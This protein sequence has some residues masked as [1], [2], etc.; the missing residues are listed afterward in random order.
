MIISKDDYT[1]LKADQV[2]GRYVVNEQLIAFLNTMTPTFKVETVGRSVEGRPVQGVT[3][4]KGKKRILMWSQMHGN[5][6]TTTKAVLDL[7]KLL[8]SN[9]NVAGQIL[10]HCTLHIIPILN[11]DGA[12]A[13]TRLNANQVDLNRD[14]QNR[15]QPE[16]V[17]LRDSYDNFKPDFCFNLHDQRTIYN[18]GTSSK[19]ATVSFLAPAHDVERSISNKRATAMKLIVAM[20]EMLQEIIPGQ[21]GRYDDAFNANCIGDTFQMLNTPTLLF[22]AGHTPG[23]YDREQTREYIFYAMVKALHVI[24]NDTIDR[25]DYHSYSRIPENE[26]RFFD[27]L[28]KNVL[29]ANSSDSKDIGILYQEI[30]A[31]G[32]ISFIPYIEQDGKLAGFFGHKTY[33]YLNEN[34]VILLRNT[35]LKEL[36]DI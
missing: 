29:M 3:I 18:V 31:E 17:I 7:I 4:G 2:Q 28:V 16:S 15:S 8:A 26:K 35:D 11:P 5:E 10:E 9:S 24:S 12:F 36:L 14:A 22:E 13:Y 1:R 6:S 21:I 27:I 25:Y 19:P 23:D 34:D 20:N 30:L 33:D 32:K